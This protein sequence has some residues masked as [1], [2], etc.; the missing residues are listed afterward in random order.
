VQSTQEKDKLFNAIATIPAIGQK[1][2]WA[3]KWMASDASFAERLFAFAVIE[4]LFF[5]GSFCAIYWLRSRGLMPGLC[6]SNDWI[7]RDE[8]LHWTFACELYKHLGLKTDASR[9]RQIIQEAVGIEQEFVCES[10]P[11]DL[12][13]M[14]RK[15]MATYIEYTADRILKTFGMKPMYNVENPFDFMRLID[16][17]AKGNF[18]EVRI[19]EY[20]KGH[21][22]E[23]DFAA[24]F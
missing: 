8:G 11:V 20:R 19:S 1:A 15:L 13:G 2:D 7:S 14:N 9:I 18:F 23:L 10:L 4:G 5:S 12:I 21:D 17:Q 22:T 24:D 16:L 3:L 6:K